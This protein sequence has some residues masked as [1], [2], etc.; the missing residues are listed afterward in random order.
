M[1][2]ISVVQVQIAH[3]FSC[4]HM[5]I[6]KKIFLFVK[7]FFLPFTLF[8]VQRDQMVIHENMISP[9]I[10]DYDC[11]SSSLVEVSPGVLCA[12]WKGGYGKGKSNRDMK[13]KVGIWL[14][15]F[16]E[17]H[18]SQPK[19]IVRSP[20]SVCWTP[21]LHKGVNGELLLFYRIGTDPRHT[22]SMIKRS[23]D[24]GLSWS[25]EEILP[26]GIIG[27]TKSK[28]LVDKEGNMICGSSVEAGSPEDEF[29]ATACWIEILS[30]QQWSKY[31]PLEIPSKRFGCIEPALFFAKDGTLKMLCR[32]RS[33][34]VGA[35]GWIWAS[36]SKDRGKTWCKLSKTNLP[37]PDSGIEVLA[38]SNDNILLIYNNSHTNRYPLSI[39]LSKD[40]GDSWSLL[41]NI[42]EQSGEF[43]SA[44]IDSQGYLHV[45]YA[46]TPT[47]KNQRQIK[48]VIMDVSDI[49]KSSY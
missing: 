24:G 31:G 38:L 45:I 21:V 32:D 20:T 34:R 44:A 39:A 18:W 13:Q 37:N 42:E 35:E 41:F 49:T 36:E 5:T 10:E 17:G 2:L 11:H 15:F 23:F 4:E 28:P 33:N 26:A 43:P 47:G 16:K 40:S 46:W 7:I 12:A 14:S 19:E 1:L 27:P 9:N 25:P 22:I 30:G 8:A 3:F 29:K 6:L 48:H